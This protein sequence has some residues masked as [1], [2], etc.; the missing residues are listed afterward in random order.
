[1]HAPTDL[2]DRSLAELVNLAVSVCD[3]R[4]GIGRIAGGPTIVSDPLLPPDVDTAIA[5]R[6]VSLR[7]PVVIFDEAALAADPSGIL[8]YAAVTLRDSSGAVRGTLALL[9]DRRR[10]FSDIR[11]RYLEQIA[12]QLTRDIEMHDAIRAG[13][14]EQ[15]RL[16][17]L[18]DEA[19]VAVFRYGIRTGRLLYVNERFAQ[20]LGYTTDEL[21]AL[22]SVTDLIAED[23]RY[24]VREMIRRREEGDDRQTRYVTKVKCR[25]G[26]TLDAEIHGAVTDL[27]G[28]RIVLGAV[29]DVTAQIAVNRQL[30][31]REKYFRMEQ[32]LAQLNRLTS[33]GRLAAQMAHEF[34]NVMMGIQP[35]VEV[36]RR[37]ASDDTILLRYT[38]VITA[39]LNRG[40][41]LT[42]D[43]LRFGRP[44]QPALRKINVQGFLAAAAEEIRPL[45]GDR[46]ELRISTPGTPLFVLADPAQLG[47]VL[48][49]LALNARDA[50]EECGGTLTIDVRRDEEG[51]RTGGGDVV[52]FAITDTGAGISRQDLPH[53]FEPLFTTRQHG[54]GLGL[55]VIF[56][57]VTA[58]GGHISVDSEPGKGTTFHLLIPAASADIKED[59]EACDAKRAGLPRLLRI[60]IVEDDDAVACGLRWSL[61]TE[62][63]AVHV[64]SR[65][66][67]ALPALFAFRPDVV[68]LDLSLPDENGRA[69]YER[70]A[71][72]S[73]VPVV[74]SS[75]SAAGADIDDLLEPSRTAFLVK[76][77]AT[78]ELLASICSLV[79]VKGEAN[80]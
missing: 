38:D 61:E 6:A 65:G 24:F 80:D 25:D 72:V 41:R 28:G 33:L 26:S 14:E 10:A 43:I 15:D 46:I 53:I 5:G 55:S 3:V 27:E 31:E 22:D 79:N 48:V 54:T 32:E 75:G 42:T 20:T 63:A 44:A 9:D 23:Q 68:V 34:N 35:I 47:Q 62:G 17:V 16:Q 67:D 51:E 21:L 78:D 70:I 7:E 60:L 36:I 74:F 2:L 39:A 29:V 4:F 37:H 40:K 64:V 59:E 18:L 58:H 45:L 1:M 73:P 8:F 50:M 57:V 52:S 77:Y 49:N 13:R 56:Q 76:P 12:A 71:D 66:A 69:V 11:R 19:P 30:R